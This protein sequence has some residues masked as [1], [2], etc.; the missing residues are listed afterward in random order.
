MALSNKGL[1]PGYARVTYSGVLFPHHMTIPVNYSGEPSPGIEPLTESKNGDI[2]PGMTML[3]SFLGNIMPFFS[4]TTVFGLC[5]FHTV[6]ATTG[7]D[8]FIFAG[9]LD[10]V[11]GSTSTRTPTVQTVITFKSKIGSLYRLYMMETI[12][13]PG[14]KQLPEFTLTDAAAVSAAYLDG[15]SPVFARKNAYLFSAVSLITKLNDKLRKQQGLA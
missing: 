2:A 12:H 14:I 15:A 9:N 10:L 13:T 8:Q 4:N 3:G 11:G 1:A 5:E 7:E 6:D